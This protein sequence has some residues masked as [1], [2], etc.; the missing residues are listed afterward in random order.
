MYW[1][2]LRLQMF[3]LSFFF[4][5][6]KQMYKNLIFYPSYVLIRATKVDPLYPAQFFLNS[7][8]KEA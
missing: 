3:L 2:V 5:E 6:N 4:K 1:H 7:P 8:Q